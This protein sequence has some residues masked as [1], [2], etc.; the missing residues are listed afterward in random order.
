MKLRNTE[1]SYGIVAKL[2]HWI[3]AALI[4]GL[5][6]L[7]WYMVGLTY[8]DPFYH[9]SLMWH[10]SL[11]IVV[12]ALIAI[13]LVWMLVDRRPRAPLS[14][15]RFDRVASRVVH[16]LLIILMVVMPV[17]GYVI[18]TEAGD[19]VPVFGLFSVPAV[20][21]VSDHLRDLAESVH[22]Y[23]VYTTAALVALH[24]LAALKHHV[25]DRDDTLRRM[26]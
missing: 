20:I 23:S 19:P 18:S 7:G 10:R 2:L 3:M 22:Y 25:I 8:Y 14:L 1:D 13:R 9:D 4:I 5:I 12:L 16:G 26:L 21:D 11:G 24:V 6:W 17:S 15:T